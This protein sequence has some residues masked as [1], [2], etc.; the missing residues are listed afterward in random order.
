[1]YLLDGNGASSLGISQRI[2]QPCFRTG[3]GSVRSE[4]VEKGCGNPGSA[5]YGLGRRFL[6]RG[7]G[8]VMGEL[9]LVCFGYNVNKLYHKIQQGRYGTW[10]HSLKQAA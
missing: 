2:S 9:L 3:G 4:A 10:Q 8:G 6:T 7:K 5:E 1:M